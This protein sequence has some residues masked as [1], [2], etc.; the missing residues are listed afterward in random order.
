MEPIRRSLLF[1]PGDRPDRIRKAATLPADVIIID[2][3]DGV[4]AS[5]KD[6]ARRNTAT[7]L[8]EVDFAERETAVRI[9][10][11]HSPFHADD[12]RAL[13]DFPRKPDLIVVSKVET[14][15]ELVALNDASWADCQWI[16]CIESAQSVLNAA[17][18]AR[19]SPNMVGL[20]FGGH[21]LAADLGTVACWE[22][23]LFARSQ[24]L[25]AAAAAG[26]EAFDAPWIDLADQDG[27]VEE[28]FR[29]R[30][31]GYVGKAAIHPQQ[32]ESINGCFSPSADEMAWAQQVVAAA[33]LSGSGAIRVNGKMVDLA[34]VRSARKTLTRARCLRG[35]ND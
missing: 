13:S 31:L 5:R 24:V 4:D 10:P 32:L 16:P 30:G 3:E 20:L 26:I 1:V 14:P 29:A 7:L 17:A 25:L 23:L 21:D 9:N 12:T 27:L 18:I 28:C 8:A 34:M 35:D 2:L 15:G 19:A 22:P 33:G 6:E 11:I